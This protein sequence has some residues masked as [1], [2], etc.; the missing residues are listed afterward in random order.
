MGRVKQCRAVLLDMRQCSAKVAARMLRDLL[1]KDS[2]LSPAIAANVLTAADLLDSLPE[3]P[4]REALPVKG[5]QTS[6]P[7]QGTASTLLRCLTVI[8]ERN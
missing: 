1:A 7:G 4:P 3:P 6:A 8:T 5:K 2:L